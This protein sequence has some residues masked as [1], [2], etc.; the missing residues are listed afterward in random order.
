[1]RKTTMQPL[2][3][4]ID[5]V[6]L[7]V[8][9]LT[10]SGDFFVDC[11]G[12]TI[13]GGKPD[14]PALYVGCGETRVTLWQAGPNARAFDRRDAVGLHHL[15][16]AVGTR[17]D[18]D[19]LH[20]RVAAWPGVQVEFGPQLSG[21]GPKVHCMIREPGGCRIEFAWSPRRG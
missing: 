11:L 1:M 19:A 21:R 12:W 4:E 3:L 20:A 14:Y 13:I 15:A 10:L 5:H 9:D 16:F 8:S 6:G 7:T 17:G 18:L 2:T